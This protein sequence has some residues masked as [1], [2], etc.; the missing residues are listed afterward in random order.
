MTDDPRLIALL[1]ENAALKA[2]APATGSKAVQ[3]V[4]AV[5]VLSGLGVA[6]IIALALAQPGQDHS[7]TINLILGLLMPSVVALLA[8]AVREN[9]L[10]MN[11]RMS[12]M[13]RLQKK[14]S[15]AEGELLGRAKAD[16]MT[17]LVATTGRALSEHDVWERDERIQA[18]AAIAENTQLTRE[19]T[20]LT[21]EILV[22][23]TPKDPPK[24]P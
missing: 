8:A 16:A 24:A 9:H 13:L 21:R 7:A 19:N 10:A 23:V 5:I 20:E 3:F 15:L 11:S 14:A 12:E 6:S 1:E 18:T 22:T 4:W 2:S 17:E